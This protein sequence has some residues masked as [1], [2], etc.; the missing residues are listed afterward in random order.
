MSAIVITSG[1]GGVGKTTLTTHL[2]GA[3]A[4][5]GLNVLLI[6]GD[7]SLRNL[8]ASLG[9]QDYIIY[10]IIDVIKKNAEL[11]DA[12]IN[13]PNLPGLDFLP[14]PQGKDIELVTPENMA[15][16]VQYA[17]GIYDFILIDCP[18]GID[19]GFLSCV[20]PADLAIIVTTPDVSAVRDAIKVKI[21]L[22]SFQKEAM[23]TFVNRTRKR[24]AKKGGCMS[25]DEV[26]DFIGLPLL[27]HAKESHMIVKAGNN[28]K[29]APKHKVF[30]IYFEMTRKLMDAGKLKE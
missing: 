26:E 12:V 17:K 9:L 11:S 23:W 10:D 22:Q 20:T 21:K 28:G 19:D 5:S 24:L 14:A 30:N 25:V 8:D 3:L 16:L 18:A 2:G 1:K 13:H 27:G 4:L 7:V 15:H 29:V 6:D